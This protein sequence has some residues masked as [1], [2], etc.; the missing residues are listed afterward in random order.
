MVDDRKIGT[1][2]SWISSIFSVDRSSGQI[3]VWGA[4]S[5]PRR[6]C[7]YDEVGYGGQWRFSVRD[8][9]VPGSFKPPW[10]PI[11]RFSMNYWIH[12][13]RNASAKTWT[14]AW[15]W[16]TCHVRRTLSTFDFSFQPVKD[17]GYVGSLPGWRSSG[18]GVLYA[19]LLFRP[20]IQENASVANAREQVEQSHE[21]EDRADDRPQPVGFAGQDQD[22]RQRDQ[23]DAH[24]NI[25]LRLVQP[26]YSW[27]CW[28]SV[29][30]TVENGQARAQA[31][32]D[33][34]TPKTAE[35]YEISY[36]TVGSEAGI[37]QSVWNFIQN[38]W[39][40][41]WNRSKCMK[42]HTKP[43]VRTLKPGKVYD[44]SYKTVGSS[45]SVASSFS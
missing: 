31:H 44:I 14:C 5:Q 9:K 22:Q 35:V 21:Q 7:G 12:H 38:R 23:G 27:V 33:G 40:G 41:R 24:V 36:K 11:R 6:F 32:D 42:F 16:R 8:L 34:R 4:E 3:S 13:F 28:S 15:N 17:E 30:E 1:R 45:T 2:T 18:Q 10:A 19:L 25:R 43:L 29:S 37:G 39:F 20:D 26:A